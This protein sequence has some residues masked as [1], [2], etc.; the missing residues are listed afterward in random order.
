MWFLE[1]KD[2]ES[3]TEDDVARITVNS[4][5]DQLANVNSPR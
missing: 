1:G 3:I 4:P 2:D 5:T